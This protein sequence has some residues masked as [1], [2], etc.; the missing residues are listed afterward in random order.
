MTHNALHIYWQAW[1]LEQAR[2]RK[3][4]FRNKSSQASKNILYG[5]FVDTFS[6]KKRLPRFN[7]DQSLLL[8]QSVFN[9]R[10]WE[11]DKRASSRIKGYCESLIQ[12][13]LV[14]R[15]PIYEPIKKVSCTPL[16]VHHF[17]RIFPTNHHHRSHRHK[18]L[19]VD[20]LRRVDAILCL[21]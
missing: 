9:K 14:N 7:Y 20:S 6:Y 11:T 10:S 5:L 21:F 8:W 16:V 4:E 18:C 19:H 1:G 3:Q 2:L 13:C 12:K 17:R 15:L